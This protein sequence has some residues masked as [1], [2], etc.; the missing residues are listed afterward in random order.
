MSLAGMMPS[1]SRFCCT[2][3]FS[4][5]SAAKSIRYQMAGTGQGDA[6][7]CRRGARLIR[8]KAFRVRHCHC[9]LPR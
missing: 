1:C 9:Q 6:M 5:R 4:T 8:I 2:N 7:T 3:A